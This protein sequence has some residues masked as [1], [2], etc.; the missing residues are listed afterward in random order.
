M[1][2]EFWALILRWSK[3]VSTS[4]GWVYKDSRLGLYTKGPDQGNDLEP[5]TRLAWKPQPKLSFN[6]M[7]LKFA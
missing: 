2:P 6:I 7:S 1:G 4:C 3:A 5:Q